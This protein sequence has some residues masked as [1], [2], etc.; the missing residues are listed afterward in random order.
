MSESEEKHQEYASA[1]ISRIVWVG[2]P[3]FKMVGKQNTT[4]PF[5]YVTLP[6]LRIKTWSSDKF[7][8]VCFEN[9]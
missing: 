7:D 8:T 4:E 3:K 1:S 5:E 2:A 6:S 9:F